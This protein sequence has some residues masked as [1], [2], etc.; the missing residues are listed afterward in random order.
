MNL[1]ITG[2]KCATS[3]YDKKII[4][5]FITSNNLDLFQH[6]LQITKYNAS[7]ALY[8]LNIIVGNL[9]EAE[10]WFVQFYKDFNTITRDSI[11]HWELFGD[12]LFVYQY[13][14]ESVRYYVKANYNKRWFAKWI[15]DKNITPEIIEAQRKS[16]YPLLKSH[17][18]LEFEFK[19]SDW[20]SK[21][22]KAI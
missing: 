8:K 19:F 12:A 13:Y 5:N 18:D 7:E 9:D 17:F 22:S 1:S 15:K 2:K 20:E 11:I 21:F 3:Q 14:N 6:D 16:C 10:K 4:P